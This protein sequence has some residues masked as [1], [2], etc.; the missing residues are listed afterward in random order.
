MLTL[1]WVI[2]LVGTGSLSFLAG[3]YV[4]YLSMKP[5]MDALGKRLKQYENHEEI[6]L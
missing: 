2:A 1:F 5:H 3:S 6:H 4:F